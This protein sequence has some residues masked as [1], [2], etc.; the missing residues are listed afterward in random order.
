MRNEKFHKYI[1]QGMDEEKAKEKVYM[2]TLW[3]LERVF[4]KL[5]KH[6]YGVTYTSEMMKI[7][8]R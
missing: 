5:S 4:F 7:T 2:K 6:I 3:A 1:N 8:W